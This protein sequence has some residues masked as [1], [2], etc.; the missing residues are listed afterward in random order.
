MDCVFGDILQRAE[1][2]H[3]GVKIG[4]FSKFKSHTEVNQFRFS[5]MLAKIRK[6]KAISQNYLM[7]ILP[8]YFQEVRRYG[9]QRK[10]AKELIP[11]RFH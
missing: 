4:D 8:I 2:L 11:D 5:S 1:K 6:L 3:A 7:L 9:P 10:E